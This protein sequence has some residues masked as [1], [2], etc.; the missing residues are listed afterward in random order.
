M[1][2]TTFVP[3]VVAL[4]PTV[5]G[6]A[7]IAAARFDA[8]FVVFVSVANVPVV[9]FGQELLPFVPG[10]T[11][12]LHANIPVFP[13]APTESVDEGPGV[14]SVTVTAAPVFDAAMPAPAGHAVMALTRSAACTVVVVVLIAIVP[15]YGPVPV[16]VFEPFPP[17]VTA[18]HAKFPVKF[19]SPTVIVAALPRRLSVTS[20]VFVLFDAV[21][22]VPAGQA[23][24]A[25]CRFPA[26]VDVFVAVT[27]VPVNVGAVPEQPTDPFV[28]GV[29][30][31]HEK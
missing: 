27:N 11:V 25:A 24:M 17:A 13:V 10:F 19:V 14:V 21:T 3:V 29:T 18:L 22:L 26:S 6:H 8:R 31:P 5:A 12:P 7:V 16:H 30:A 9:E 1:T 23:A 2:V 4:T 28:P 15:V 20:T